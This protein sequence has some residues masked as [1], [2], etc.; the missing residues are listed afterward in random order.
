MDKGKVGAVASIIISAII[1]LAALWGYN[2]IVVQPLQQQ[3]NQAAPA[4]ATGDTNFTNVVASGSVAAGTTLTAGT[5]TFRGVQSTVTVTAN[6]TIAVT[7]DIVPLTA[8][9]TVGTGTIT[10]CNT[11]GKVTTFYNTANQTITISDTSTIMLAA[12]AALG[13]YDT[14]TVLG[15]GTN[16]LGIA[17]SNN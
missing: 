6:G 11:A 7:A 15:D 17:Q 9:G 4:G 3:V 16:C 13:Q 5:S 2:V 10:G 12:N 1:A 8:A 14:L